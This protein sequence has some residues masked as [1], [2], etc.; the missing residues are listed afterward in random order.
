MRGDRRGQQG[1]ILV[2]TAFL[3]PFI[4][5]FTGFAVDAGNAY[6]HHSKLQNSVDAAA[7]AG[8]YKYIEKKD[9]TDTRNKID[10][11]MKLNQGN[12]SYTIDKI[13]YK[14]IDDNHVKI[15]VTTSQILP[16]FFLGTAMKLFSHDDNNKDLDQWDIKTK[17]SVLVE[18]DKKTSTSNSIFDYAMVGGHV[19][20]ADGR[21][22]T[23]YSLDF[24]TPNVIIKGKVH[25]NGPVAVASN[26]N[27]KI[28][29][30]S[31]NSTS[32][33]EL[34][35]NFDNSNGSHHYDYNTGQWTHDPGYENDEYAKSPW[36]DGYD[37]RHY[38]RVATLDDKDYT[39]E[40]SQSKY[41][42]INLSESNPL[43]NDLGKLILDYLSMSD[44]KKESNHIYTN[45]RRWDYIQWQLDRLLGIEPIFPRN[46]TTLIHGQG[47][48]EYPGL[49][50]EGPPSSQ[51]YRV[52]IVSGDLTVKLSNMPEFKN[53]GEHMLLISLYGNIT[54]TDDGGK[55]SFYGY[56]YAPNGNVSL[57]GLGKV[58]GSIIADSISVTMPGSRIEHRTFSDTGSNGDGGNGS[59]SVSLVSD[60]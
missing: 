43:T 40:N 37:W 3:L 17:A 20:K 16:T 23:K 55:N 24:I 30:F 53:D 33:A 48:N 36:W 44:N 39:A 45:V 7:L 22:N 32:D 11:Y 38:R 27:T 54:V 49:T 4:I 2:L 29:S 13:T 47:K 1:A 28:E 6:V 60:D 5:A 50:F 25:T 35:M 59:G 15:T 10:E 58:Y 8:G 51:Y 14:P 12:D 42:D 46:S 52:V 57:K 19:G 26:H 31:H 9:E 21:W 34:W 56:I 41:V 18:L